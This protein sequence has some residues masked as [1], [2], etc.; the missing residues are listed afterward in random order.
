D[1]TQNGPVFKGYVASY[2]LK[3]TTKDFDQVGK[4]IDV[5]VANGANA[6]DSVQFT[7]SKELEEQVRSEALKKAGQ[8]ARMKAEATAEGLGVELGDIVG[9]SESSFYAQ[10]YYYAKATE[11]V[12]AG[13]PAADL[14]IEPSTIQV[15]ASLN[16]AYE[17]DD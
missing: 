10:P 5:A 2:S 15:S 8:T 1:Y 11:A 12:A 14:V 9:V 7:L 3:V 16:V 17:I 6:I 4:I 13:R